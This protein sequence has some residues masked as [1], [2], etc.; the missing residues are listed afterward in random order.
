MGG[1]NFRTRAIM[2]IA[3][4]LGVSPEDVADETP[5]VVDQCL[6]LEVP[7]LMAT[8]RWGEII[9]DGQPWTVRRFL[10]MFI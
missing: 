8:G 3:A 5:L 9:D 7:V 1:E 10:R 2:I 4:Y 6:E